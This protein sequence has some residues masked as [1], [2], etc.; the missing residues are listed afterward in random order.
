MHKHVQI[1]QLYV[2]GISHVY[3]FI[4]L[5]EGLP[6]STICAKKLR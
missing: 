4:C 1:R 6:L 2:Y 5:F 3:I